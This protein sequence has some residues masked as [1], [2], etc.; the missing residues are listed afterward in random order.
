MCKKRS[1]SAPGS[2]HDGVTLLNYTVCVQSRP[3]P[4]LPT[5][6]AQFP[7][8]PVFLP[9]KQGDNAR[10]ISFLQPSRI[11]DINEVGQDGCDELCPAKLPGF[12]HHFAAY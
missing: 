6:Y 9:R 3:F 7:S 8:A 11:R 2:G 4:D 10:G 12:A 5:F 1:K